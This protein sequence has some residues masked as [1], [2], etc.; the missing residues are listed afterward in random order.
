MKILF[1][2]AKLH[3][4]EPFGLMSLAPYLLRDGHEVLL[5]E[6]E[7]PALESKV[8]TL[9]PDLIGY[10]VCTG[11][12]RYYLALNRALKAHHPFISIFGG[13]HPT[14]FPEL[15]H[16]PGVDALCRGEGELAFAEFCR[17]LAATGRIPVIP[18]FTV[19]IGDKIQSLPPR[20]LI[21]DAD[22]IL[23]PARDLY[24]NVSKEIASHTIR[25]FLAARGCPFACSY[26]FNPAM[27]TLYQGKWKLTR[28]RS[29]KNLVEEIGS[30]ATRYPTEFVAFRESIFPLK[31]D[32]LREFA[33]LYSRQVGLPFYCHVRLDMLTPARVE[34]LAKAGCYSVN[35]GI[36][37]GNP[38][39][40]E[41]LLNRR[42]SNQTMIDACALLRRHKIKILANNMLGLPGASL[43]HDLETM[44]LNQRCK[45]DYA[46]AMLCQPYPGTGLADYAKQHGY[47]TGE[48]QELDFTYYNRSHLQFTSPREKRRIEN[49]QKL[50]AV[51]VALPLL[52]PLIRLLTRL[53]Q[54]AIFKA[55]F[56]VMY[57]VFH[58][59]IFRTRRSPGGWLRNFRHIVR[60][61]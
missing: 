7:D 57:L 27:N 5:L 24:Y 26:C 51:G 55:I 37:T 44:A 14:F 49:L 15:I 32:W 23:F 40:R 12:E 31:E 30:V 3:T 6:A 25:S 59:E 18:N 16:E 45:P 35:V 4:I 28:T 21:P 34:L 53:P 42:I 47:Y 54:N 11:S 46:L 10:S 22:S 61:T 1:L 52:T 50:F 17:E 58:T 39:L 29:P 13:P 43:D 60:E 33:D 2:G 20:P 19:K 48:D 36:E 56:R 8:Q 9:K 41:T 38:A